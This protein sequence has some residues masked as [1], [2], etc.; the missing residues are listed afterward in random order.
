MEYPTD[1][2]CML[3]VNYL[4]VHM[5]LRRMGGLNLHD[6]LIQYCIPDVSK[7]ET[8]SESV[9]EI[10]FSLFWQIHIERVLQE[11][12]RLCLKLDNFLLHC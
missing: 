9:T 1:K 8:G 6:Y 5:C 2:K 7:F 3:S 11:C 10:S 12:A 4:N